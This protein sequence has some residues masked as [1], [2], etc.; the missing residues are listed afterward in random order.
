[1]AAKGEDEPGIME[2]TA[3]VPHQIAAAYL[4]EATAVFDAATAPDPATAMVDP[5]PTPVEFLVRH[6]L[7]PRA[8]LSQIELNSNAGT[9]VNEVSRL[10][11]PL[12]RCPQQRVPFSC[13][14]EARSSGSRRDTMTSHL[15]S[16]PGVL[17]IKL[18][19]SRAAGGC[20]LSRRPSGW[21]LSGAPR[22]S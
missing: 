22:A 13:R 21:P 3:D 7:L 19:M 20:M 9:W 10:A 14:Q 1:M 8:L 15:A 11:T 4:P 16:F 2:G 18:A 12:N 6:V 5:Q 17:L